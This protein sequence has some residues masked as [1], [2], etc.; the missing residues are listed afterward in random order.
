[1]TTDGIPNIL[2]KIVEAKRKEVERL[3]TELPVAA[4]EERI[5]VQRPPLNLSGALW[6][7]SVRI[8]AEVKKASPSKGLLRDDF[9]PATLAKTYVDNG[10][11]AISVLTNVDHFQGS[12]D[13]LSAVHGVAN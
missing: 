11:A 1:M 8:I 5:A 4:L 12:I 2:Q 6:G 9:D 13:D 3:K 7:D 10:A